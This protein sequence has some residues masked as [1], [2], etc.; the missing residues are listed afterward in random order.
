MVLVVSFPLRCVSCGY[1]LRFTNAVEL[2]GLLLV[3][4]PR[5][6]C[7]WCREYLYGSCVYFY[8]TDKMV[9]YMV[10]MKQIGAMVLVK[11]R[12]AKVED[13]NG[14]KIYPIRADG[15]PDFSKEASLVWMDALKSVL[16]GA[17]RYV[18]V[19]LSPV[20]VA[21]SA[22]VASGQASAPVK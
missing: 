17:N 14:I 22:P 13:A 12:E 18:P 7:R 9:F 5:S 3:W 6:V 20:Y 15:S 4:C 10:E 8:S 11:K 19:F 21:P 16:S 2:C 1:K